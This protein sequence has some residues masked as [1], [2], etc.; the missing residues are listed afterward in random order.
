MSDQPAAAAPETE[1][2][3]D[4]VDMGAAFDAIMARDG[5]MEE[6]P[7]E[8][9]EQL[10]EAQAD[11]PAPEG[12]E[13]PD[14]QENAAEEA[15]A[16]VS[17]P[18]SQ[19]PAAVKA[20]WDKFTP[21][22]REAIEQRERHFGEMGRLVSGLRPIQTT[23]TEMVQEFPALSHMKPEE[24]IAEMRGLAQINQA[25][26][27]DPV[28]AILGLVQQH[29]LQDRLAAAMQGVQ[30]GQTGDAARTIAELRQEIAGMKRAMDPEHMRETFASW[31][32][33]A[34]MT[35]T[36]EQFAADHADTWSQVEPHLPAAIQAVQSFLGDGADPK[37]VLS[38]AYE[39][40]AGQ[41]GI[42]AKASQRS[43]AAT[44][45]PP[46]PERSKAVK[47]AESV[48]VSGSRQGKPRE[49]TEREMLSQKYDEIISRE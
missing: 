29:G 44:A 32:S 22:A 24:V 4:E 48:N 15:P 27:D 37:S 35:N 49:M 5:G 16:S 34:T 28:R 6:E 47:T 7:A 26:N 14:A 30:P 20:A 25:F 8:A 10:A 45:A 36:V 42:Q 38:Q 17:A 18:P 33:E 9:A 3:S 13:E 40:A 19:L 11:E 1:S 46:N 39:L 43:A 2:M 23:L 41:L 21:E 31:Q 12:A